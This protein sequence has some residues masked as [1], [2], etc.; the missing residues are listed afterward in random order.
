MSAFFIRS[1]NPE[2]D[3]QRC[4]ESQRFLSRLVIIAATEQGE[5]K[6]FEGVVSQ[7]KTM[8]RTRPLADD[9]G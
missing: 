6:L 1:S 8:V 5:I 4:H 3:L 7:S 9:G 2:A